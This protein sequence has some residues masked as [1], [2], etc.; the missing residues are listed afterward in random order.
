MEKACF[1]TFPATYQ[2]IKAEKRLAGEKWQFKMVPVPR[3]ISSSC[4]IALRCLPEE[5]PEIKSFLEINYVEI[6]GIYEIEEKA[7]P[8]ILSIFSRRGKNG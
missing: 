1:F 5:A 2:A 4:G 8:G 3:S 7:A 6:E